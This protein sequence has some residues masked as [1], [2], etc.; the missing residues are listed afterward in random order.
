M[1]RTVAATT[2]AISDR[3]WFDRRRVQMIF[4]A[5]SRPGRPVAHAEL[6]SFCHVLAAHCIVST[7]HVNAVEI[8]LG[9]VC[10]VTM[11]RP[12]IVL[13][14]CLMACGDNGSG[15]GDQPDGTQF[16]PA[17]HAPM[18]HVLRHSGTVLSSPQLVTITFDGYARRDHVEQFAAAVVSSSWYDTIGSEYGLA[19]PRLFPSVRLPD[20][21]STVSRDKITALITQH[22][23]AGTLPVP[24]RDNQLLYLLY[25]PPGVVR[26]RDLMSVLAYHE[27]AM[28]ESTP[29]PFVVVLDDNRDPEQL[30]LAVAHQL[31]NATANPYKPPN[32]G[33]YADPPLIDPWSLVHGELADLCAGE[34]PVTEGG[35]LFPRV[36]SDSAAHAGNTP[37][38]PAADDAWSDVSAKPPTLSMVPRG[39]SVTYVLTGWSTKPVPDWSLRTRMADFSDLTLD[40]MQPELSS[41]KINNST[42]VELTLHAPPDATLGAIGGIYILSG[43]NARPWAVGFFVH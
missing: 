34:T 29:F 22:I 13:S 24:T 21:P 5:L 19:A 11:R 31:I 39:G 28:T 10:V 41:D 16:S 9:L 7:G 12:V 33:Y 35:F 8:V 6:C 14:A 37:C 27:V 3:D 40:Q 15:E 18:P 2:L 30:T 42:T 1:R 43:V 23:T 4:A 20:A 17:P 26:S 32:D 36:Y 25:I 38:E